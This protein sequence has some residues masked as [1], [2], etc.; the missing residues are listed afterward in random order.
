MSEP[1]TAPEY[2][3]QLHG[4]D[5]ATVLRHAVLY[6]LVK[7]VNRQELSQSA[8]E[9][10]EAGLRREIKRRRLGNA[11]ERI[12][13]TARTIT[14]IGAKYDYI[15]VM[16]NKETQRGANPEA[17]GSEAPLM[18]SPPATESD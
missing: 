12:V 10:I 14:D 17:S 9:M 6:D 4:Q 16:A 1:T 18:A 8:R 5:D 11:R 15:V 3:K 13:T 7:K 2:I